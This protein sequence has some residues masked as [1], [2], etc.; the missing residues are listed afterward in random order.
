MVWPLHSYN[1]N[2][3]ASTQQ[4]KQR[5]M[6]LVCVS[7]QTQVSSTVGRQRDAS[8]SGN[9]ARVGNGDRDRLEIGEGGMRGG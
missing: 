4:V 9:L 1:V 2:E 6:L 5:R 7:C 8:I 3:W